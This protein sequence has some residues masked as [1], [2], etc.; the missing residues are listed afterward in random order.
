MNAYKKNEAMKEFY[1]NNKINFILSITGM[2]FVSILFV[3]LAII[4]QKLLDI[5]YGG[6]KND[7]FKMLSICVLYI[8][9]SLLAH[10]C[11]VI[12]TNKFINKAMYQ[13]KQYVFSRVL[14]KS[15]NSFNS[16]SPSTYVSA[17]TNDMRLIEVNYLGGTLKIILQMTLLIG[18]LILMSYYSVIILIC[19]LVI[20]L[21]PLVISSIISPKIT[22][23]EKFSHSFPPSIC[24]IYNS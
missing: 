11:K 15:I 4:L 8:L 6:T 17:L 10:R 1:K 14:N 23:Y 16:E 3:S 20:S 7:L 13:Y 2:I 19:V 9:L 18:G 12:F 24:H 22:T 5:A 21:I